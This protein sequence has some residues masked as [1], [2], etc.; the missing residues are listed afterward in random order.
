MAERGYTPRTAEHQLRQVGRFSVWLESNGVDVAQLSQRHVEDFLAFQRGV[1]RYRAT[2]SRPGLMCLI[3]V[4]ESLSVLGASEPARA[5][6]PTEVVLDAFEHYL[7]TERGLAV[8]T[9]RGYVDHAHRFLDGLGD[10]ELAYVGPSAVT[11]A[12]LRESQAVSVSA[13]KNFRSGL[14]AF[15]RFGY[16]EGRSNK[17]SVLRAVFTTRLRLRVRFD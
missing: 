9:V 17:S 2:W 14:R 11:D 1:G 7:L 12:L 13:T 6:T 15:L 4:L 16:V 3:E 10:S 8:G 5:L